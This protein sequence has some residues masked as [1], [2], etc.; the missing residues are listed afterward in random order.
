MNLKKALFVTLFTITASTVSI[1]ASASPTG[2]K[3]TVSSGTAVV[4]YYGRQFHGRTT[5]SGQKF[6]MHGM[7]VAHKSLPFGTKV[8]F[9]CELTGKKVIATVNDRGPYIHG[10]KFDLSQGA[11]TK[12]GIVDRGVAKV[13]YQILK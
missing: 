11:A 8:E 1:E 13:S 10:R 3:Q 5:A 4:S 9:T 6:N 7:T 2:N 12:L